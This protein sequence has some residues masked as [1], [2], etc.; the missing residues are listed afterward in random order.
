MYKEGNWGELGEWGFGQYDP[1][2]PK[3]NKGGGEGNKYMTSL[4]SDRSRVFKGGSWRDRAYWMAPGT[5]R[6]LDEKMSRDD[7]GFRCAMDRLGSSRKPK[8]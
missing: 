1:T 7:L 3:A 4:V 6:F 5:R 8:K 2:N